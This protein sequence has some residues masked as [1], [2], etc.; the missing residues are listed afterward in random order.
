MSRFQDPRVALP[1]AVPPRRAM[2]VGIAAA[3]LL[4]SAGA[5]YSG[6]CTDQIAALKQQI[7]ALPAGP[8]TGPDLFTDPRRAVASPTDA[9]RRSARSTGRPERGGR[10]PKAAEK[11]DAAGNASACN[12][13]LDR[14]QAPVRYRSVAPREGTSRAQPSFNKLLRR[15]SDRPT[16]PIPCIF[17][18]QFLRRRRAALQPVFQNFE[19]ARLVLPVGVETFAGASSPARESVRTLVGDLE[20]GAA[21]YRRGETLFRHVVAQLLPLF[22]R[23]NA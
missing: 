17:L 5:A 23:S 22:A 4:G 16:R 15:R 10:G 2:L 14:G 3:A 8:K 9:R 7:K 12:A 6:P 13:A 21:A 18:E 20:H 19:I 1:R 11:A